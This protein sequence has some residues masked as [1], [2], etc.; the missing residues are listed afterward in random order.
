MNAESLPD[1]E[2]EGLE[3]NILLFKQHFYLEKQFASPQSSTDKPHGAAC[4]EAA[5]PRSH[6]GTRGTSISS[7]FI[8]TRA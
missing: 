6:P 8:I 4:R 7:P 1:A 2:L 5:V 3:I